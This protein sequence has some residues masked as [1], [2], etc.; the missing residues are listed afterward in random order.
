MEKTNTGMIILIMIPHLCIHFKGFL[1]F[2]LIYVIA[3]NSSSM[4]WV[5]LFLFAEESETQRLEQNISNCF[6]V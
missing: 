4:V 2:G 3:H 1:F 6:D 5:M